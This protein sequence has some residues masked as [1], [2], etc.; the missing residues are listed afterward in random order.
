MPRKTGYKRRNVRR[1]R[2]G[3]RRRLVGGPLA[4]SQHQNVV[5]MMSN[6]AHPVVQAAAHIVNAAN[7]YGPQAATGQKQAQAMFKKLAKGLVS[8]HN[9]GKYKALSQTGLM[10]RGQYSKM[11]K[12]RHNELSGQGKKFVPKGKGHSTKAVGKTYSHP[13]SVIPAWKSKRLGDYKH[14]IWQTVCISQSSR[15]PGSS[16]TL[17]LRRAPVRVQDAK[18]GRVATLLFTP[19]CSHY[20]GIHTTMMR[21]N[22][23]DWTTLSHNGATRFDV[24][25]NKA[26]E[27]EK[28]DNAQSFLEGRTEDYPVYEGVNSVGT[29]YSAATA[30]GAAN[31][32]RIH[33]HYDLLVS[34]VKVD[35][36]F[37]QNRAFETIINVSVIRKKKP[38]T[39]YALSIDETREICNS[40]KN[41]LDPDEWIVEWDTTVK[42]A[43][44]KKNKPIPT[45]SVNHELVCNWLMTNTFESNTVSDD[46]AQT[47]QTEL[48]Q[49]IESKVSETTDD[50]LAGQYFVV[51]KYAKATRNTP[52]QFEY[53][54]LI[55]SN[56]NGGPEAQITVPCV[57]N[58][59]FDIPAPTGANVDSSTGKPM[60]GNAEDE[61]LA[62]FYMQGKLIYGWKSKIPT[63]RLPSLMA[64]RSDSTDYKKAQSLMIDPTHTGSDTHSI[65]TQSIDHVNLAADT[66]TTGP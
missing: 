14:N 41:T 54:Q 18:Q 22:S 16:N 65:Y 40:L 44:L 4:T 21:Q 56:S 29:S 13:K 9:K 19:F 35:L 58:E 34:S 30:R 8:K 36:V 46:Y 49:S 39:P 50:Q 55:Q 25:Q 53:T 17:T 2:G 3:R 51:V 37:F 59:S 15:L 24:I 45:A 31:L 64:C 63:Q 62:S 12:N 10:T 6:R 48:G 33:A 61:S 11:S 28:P 47:A 38:N 5:A 23:A 7:T 57:R 43:A 66:S 20:S 32:D 27:Q 60:A 26:Q 1:N 52:Q 42:L